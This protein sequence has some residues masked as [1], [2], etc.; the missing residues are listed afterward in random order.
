MYFEAVVQHVEHNPQVLTPQQDA[1]PTMK[2]EKC[3][4]FSKRIEYLGPLT[5]LSKIE[6]A[7]TTT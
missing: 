5:N 1:G 6:I 3:F 2:L 7:S 4:F